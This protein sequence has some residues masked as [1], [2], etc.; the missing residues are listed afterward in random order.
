MTLTPSRLFGL[1]GFLHGEDITPK[2]NKRIKRFGSV[3]S[4][5]SPSCCSNSCCFIYH[6]KFTLSQFS[7]T[8]WSIG[9]KLWPAGQI[10]PTVELYIWA[11]KQYEITARAAL[12]VV[13]STCASASTTNPRMP[14]G[15]VFFSS[16]L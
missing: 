11:T 4:S 10:C 1:L 13:D 2:L 6:L 15:F 9:F 8:T 12:P 3:C 5:S 7:Q 16:L 14:C